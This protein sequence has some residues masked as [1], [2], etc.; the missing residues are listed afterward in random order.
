MPKPI[1]PPKPPMTGE[2]LRWRVWIVACLCSVAMA[3]TVS[4]GT[5]ALFGYV[6]GI[7]AE[8]V[9]VGGLNMISAVGQIGHALLQEIEHGLM[10]GTESDRVAI[11]RQ[12]S[13]IDFSEVEG[14]PNQIYCA[15][16]SNLNHE[17]VQVR[18]EAQ[19]VLGLLHQSPKFKKPE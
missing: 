5:L 12:L 2:V 17:S 6:A 16:E 1:K 13:A 3:I 9:L 18:A 7:A 11:L 10:E 14:F 19:N 8:T 15:I 4:A